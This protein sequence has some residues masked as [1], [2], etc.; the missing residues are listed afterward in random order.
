MK[1]S[2]IREMNIEQLKKFISEKRTQSVKLR[3]D[4]SAKQIKNHREYRKT[5]KEIAQA[6]TIL[7][8]KEVK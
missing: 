3:F 4:I 7:K 1:A 8:E 5:R 6:L 2:E